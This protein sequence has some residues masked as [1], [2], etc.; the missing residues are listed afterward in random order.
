MNVIPTLYFSISYLQRHQHRGLVNLGGMTNLRATQCGALNCYGLIYA[1]F[2]VD[3]VALDRFSLQVPAIFPLIVIPQLLHTLLLPSR[4]LGDSPDQA[5]HCHFLGPKICGFISDPALLW[6]QG[7][8]VF[9][10]LHQS[11]LTWTLSL[12]ST[13]S[14]KSTLLKL[15]LLISV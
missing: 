4:V 15:Y 13:K 9:C 6:S 3:E 8:E 11:I 10:F 14:V 7:M 2:V 1:R 5:E 12:E